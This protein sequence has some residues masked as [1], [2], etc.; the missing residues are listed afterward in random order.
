V[1]EPEFVVRLADLEQGPKEITWKLSL[2]WLALALDATDASPHEEGTLRV[3]LIKN[4]E[5]VVVRGR[6]H[7]VVTMP[8]SRTLDP[9]QVELDPEIFLML[10]RASEPAGTHRGP[11]PHPPSAQKPGP[12]NASRAHSWADDPRLSDEEAARDVFHGESVV[13]DTFLREFILLELPMNPVRSDLHA[14]P[15]QATAPRPPPAGAP[16]P[17]LAPLAA[18]LGRMREVRDDKDK[19]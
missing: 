3:E 2:P 14:P 4:G 9:M 10:S 8:C 15:E 19:E 7:V 11:R 18:L 17:R 12:A 1:P 6:A 16:D 5:Q 13:L